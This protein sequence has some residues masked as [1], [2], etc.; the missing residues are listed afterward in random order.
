MYRIDRAVKVVR[1]CVFGCV[2]SM[3]GARVSRF[4]MIFGGICEF[5]WILGNCEKIIVFTFFKFF[6]FASE[7][8]RVKRVRDM[9]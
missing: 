3:P 2:N 8:D 1:K 6:S 9:V 5:G 4:F 7:Y